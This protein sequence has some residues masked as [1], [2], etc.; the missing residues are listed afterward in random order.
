MLL[1]VVAVG[2]MGIVLLGV[3][4]GPA[5]P[6]EIR[7]ERSEDSGSA[8]V[9]G[10]ILA[11]LQL[12]L[13]TLARAGRGSA[14]VGLTLTA[15]CL[16]VAT[17]LVGISALVEYADKTEWAERVGGEVQFTGAGIVGLVI[18]GLSAVLTVIGIV[19]LFLPKTNAYFAEVR[20]LRLGPLPGESGP[21]IEA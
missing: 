8:V 5:D 21:T 18:S 6:S 11:I 10:L 17:L 19:L 20:R 13:C 4:G 12:V 7:S 16:G 14:R 1:A 9:I 15:S 2:C 3:F